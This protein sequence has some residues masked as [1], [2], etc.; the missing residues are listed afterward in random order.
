[1]TKMMLPNDAR[2]GL[3]LAC[4]KLKDMELHDKLLR[5]FEEW[6]T[7]DETWG[8]GDGED[9]WLKHFLGKWISEETFPYERLKNL[10][11]WH[12]QHEHRFL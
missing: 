1:M 5:K 7:A 10:V 8:C 4:W 11:V 3:F 6:L 2:D 9:G 12:F